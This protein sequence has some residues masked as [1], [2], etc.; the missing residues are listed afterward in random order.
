[1]DLIRRRAVQLDKVEYV[2]LD[3][4]DEML[5]MGFKEDIDTILEH[6]GG[7]RAIWLFSATMP[8]AIR[9]IVKKYMEKPLEVVV[10]TTE[11]SNK[12]ITHQ[13]V[14]TKSSDKMGA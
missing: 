14:V 11:I 1:M 4:A 10:N 2:I 12:D 3:E 5:N 9:R 8:P 6:T 13:Y 7:E